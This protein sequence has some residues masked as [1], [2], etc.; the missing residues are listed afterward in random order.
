[1]SLRSLEAEIL[2]ELRILTGDRTIRQKDIMEWSTSPVTP[3]G[4]EVMVS[5][6]FPIFPC[7][8]SHPLSRWKEM[9][10]RGGLMLDFGRRAFRR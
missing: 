8:Q 4:D 9:A 6:L 1:M 5:L 10:R 7:S 2:A 3:Q